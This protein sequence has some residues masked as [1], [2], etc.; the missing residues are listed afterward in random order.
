MALTSLDVSFEP[1]LAE[2][3]LESACDEGLTVSGWLAR[4]A[5]MKLRRNALNDLIRKLEEEQGLLTPEEV[6]SA[7]RTIYG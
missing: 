4:A 2:R 5:E 7:R 6:I 1:D 3:V